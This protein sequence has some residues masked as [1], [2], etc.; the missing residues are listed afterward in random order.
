M[1]TKKVNANIREQVDLKKRFAQA[2]KD[3]PEVCNAFRELWAYNN[4]EFQHSDGKNSTFANYM[5]EGYLKKR[6]ENMPFFSKSNCIKR[7]FKINFTEGFLTIQ[8]DKHSHYP[9]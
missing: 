6:G 4:R 3:N 7:Y 9:K 1:T 2:T 5:M 8:F